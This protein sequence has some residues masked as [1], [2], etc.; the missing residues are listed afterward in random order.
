MKNLKKLL[1]L[2]VAII[3][4]TASLTFSVSAA[5]T[6]IGLS[7]K[8]LQVGDTVTVTISINADAAMY[9]YDAYLSYNADILEY[10]SWIGWEYSTYSSSL[11]LFL[12]VYPLFI[13]NLP[14]WNL[15]RRFDFNISYAFIWVSFKFS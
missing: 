13:Q 3:I 5:S 6:S 7:K 2:I 12:A 11:F 8:N 14:F 4:L 10:K 15:T 9:G 1:S